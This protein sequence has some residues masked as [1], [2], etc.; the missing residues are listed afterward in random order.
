MNKVGGLHH[1]AVTTSDIKAQ[2]EF[3]TDKLGMELVALYWMHGVE[4]TFH[5]FLRLNDESAIASAATSGGSRTRSRGK[6][7]PA[8]MGMP[9]ALKTREKKRLA[10][11]REKVARPMS[12]A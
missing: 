5:G 10:R 12:M 2:I 4:N 11:M 3:F 1:L 8:A 6:R 7:A 9:R